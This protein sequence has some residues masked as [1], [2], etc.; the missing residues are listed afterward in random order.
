MKIGH[1]HINVFPGKAQRTD[2]LTI[3]SRGTLNFLLL[4]LT[5]HRLLYPNTVDFG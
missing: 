5:L 3:M 1:L 2:K 4:T